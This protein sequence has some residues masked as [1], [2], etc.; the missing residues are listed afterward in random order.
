MQVVGESPAGGAAGR[1][2]VSKRP[3]CCQAQP[4]IELGCRQLGVATE[5]LLGAAECSMWGSTRIKRP[6]NC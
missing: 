3:C 5:S 6:G 1:R 2:S 4:A